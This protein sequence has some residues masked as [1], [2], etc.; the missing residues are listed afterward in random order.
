MAEDN[1]VF[2]YNFSS[3]YHTYSVCLKSGQ[4]FSPKDLTD[5]WLFHAGYEI[6]KKPSS[7]F[8]L[9]LHFSRAFSIPNTFSALH[10]RIS[11]LKSK[12]KYVYIVKRKRPRIANSLVQD[13]RWRDN[14]RKSRLRKAAVTAFVQHTSMNSN[15]GTVRNNRI[16]KDAGV[17]GSLSRIDQQTIKAMCPNHVDAYEKMHEHAPLG[18]LSLHDTK[19][20]Y[21]I[22]TIQSVF[23][24]L[25]LLLGGIDVVCKDILRTELVCFGDGSPFG[26][27]CFTVILIVIALFY[28]YE[29]HIISP[30]WPIAVIDL[31]EEQAI[32]SHAQ[33][34]RADIYYFFHHSEFIYKLQIELIVLSGDHKWI[35]L[36]FGV[37]Q[38]SGI[39]RC[40]KC[41]LPQPLWQFCMC[42]LPTW[43]DRERT[44]MSRNSRLAHMERHHANSADRGHTIKYKGLK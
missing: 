18:T 11:T 34:L 14:A 20:G 9:P 36:F 1:S 3:P 4:P 13:R 24:Y 29:T 30:Y 2:T 33:L 28:T 42:F 8:M 40:C 16:L 21:L 6:L 22:N 26:S 12:K 35:G 41:V 15:N 37:K 25:V 32:P 5:C 27:R 10:H 38:G 23:M 43:I 17:T 31:S 7:K 44:E 19:F 39:F